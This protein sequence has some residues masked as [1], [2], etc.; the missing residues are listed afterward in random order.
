[1]S[2]IQTIAVR[3]SDDVRGGK[4]RAGS[5]RIYVE[6][7]SAIFPYF[8]KGDPGLIGEFSD[9]LSDGYTQDEYGRFW[10]SFASVN[11]GQDGKV[12]WI[13]QAGLICLLTK[14]QND[15]IFDVQERK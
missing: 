3:L 12:L 10:P 14:H 13:S 8:I 4:G 2:E 7:L 15:Y 1:M 11:N 9:T 6:H 5:V